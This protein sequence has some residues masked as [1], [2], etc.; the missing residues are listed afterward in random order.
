MPEF[1]VNISQMGNHFARVVLRATTNADAISGWAT[2]YERFP[3][4]EGWKVTLTR[5]ES[6]TGRDITP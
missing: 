5:W 1:E 2:F 3:E 6:R 4:K